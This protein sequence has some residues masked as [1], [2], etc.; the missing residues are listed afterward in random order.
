MPQIIWLLAKRY[1]GDYYKEGTISFMAIICFVGIFIGTCALA[2]IICI[3]S[4]FEEVTYQKLQTMHAPIIIS[5]VG[6]PLNVQAISKVLDQE[7]LEVAAYSPRYLN[8]V[9]VADEDESMSN[10]LV[11]QAVAPEKESKVS[12]IESLIISPRSNNKL[13]NLLQKNNIIIGKKLS[14]ILGV[15]VGETIELFYVSENVGGRKISLQ[16]KSAVVAGI[17]HAGIEEFDANMIICSLEFLH[18]LFPDAGIT[19]IGVALKK[20]S[21]EQKF[22]DSLSKRLHLEVYSWKELYPALLAALKLEK[23]AMFFILVLITLVASMNIMS[24]LFMF[25]TQKKGDIAILKAHGCTNFCIK[26]IFLVI[27]FF[28]TAVSAL[29]GLIV[30]FAIGW[31]IKTYPFIKLPDVYYVSHLP[32]YMEF[33]FFGFVFLIVMLLSFIATLVPLFSTKKIN[34]AHLLRHEA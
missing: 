3:M 23:Y 20:N 2:L 30:A 13:S 7:F 11:I 26:S 22:I 25:T 18:K 29:F 5:A 34:I 28:L 14:E 12:T 31:I 6:K 33:K 24:L 21:D 8:H 27:T 16:Q 32:I 17:F 10:V 1:M 15:S 4:G 19:Q 9:I